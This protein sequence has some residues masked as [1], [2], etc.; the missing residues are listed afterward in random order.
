MVKIVTQLPK[1]FHIKP[2]AS[3][4]ITI[5]LNYKIE[6]RVLQTNVYPCGVCAIKKLGCWG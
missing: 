1:G 6:N 2:S 4:I 3:T 5:I